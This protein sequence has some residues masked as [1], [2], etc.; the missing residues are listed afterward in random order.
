MKDINIENFNT[1]NEEIQDG[2][3]YQGIVLDEKYLSGDGASN[4]IVSI[5][6]KEA[7]EEIQNVISEVT[8]LAFVT[9]D[10]RGEPLTEMTHFTKFCQ[11]VRNDETR[12]INC[13]LS[14]ASGAIRAAVTKKTSNYFCPCGLLEVAIPIVVNGR[15]LGGFIGGQVRCY[16]APTSVEYITENRSHKKTEEDNEDWKEIKV[17]RYK[18]FEAISKLIELVIGQLTKQKIISLHHK[19]KNTRKISLLEERLSDLRCENKLLRD[20][21]DVLEKSSRWDRY[22]DLLKSFECSDF[23]ELYQDLPRLSAHILENI[24]D[25]RN[26][27]EEL[28]DISEEIFSKNECDRYDKKN[29]EKLIDKG[30]NG[31]YKNLEFLLFYIID[32]CFK[33]RAIR[34]HD[35]LDSVISYIE[36]NVKENISLSSVVNECSISQAY[37]S[38][39]FKNSFNTTVVNYIHLKKMMIAKEMLV[40][41]DVNISGL[42][43][44]LSY[45][46]SS[47]FCKVFKK[48]NNKTVEQYKQEM[49]NNI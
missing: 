39:I 26:A 32:T 23:L 44:Q 8:G 19:E 5:F 31:K 25:E 11:K 4:D 7:L 48:Y 27:A 41:E 18:E 47:Y 38:R 1:N 22:S 3:N 16:D 14:D 37:L 42:A 12:N 28:I 40:Y 34:T 36:E 46:E 43:F 9:V 21:I 10:Y 6:G 29:L 20:R 24:D 30:L 49:T 45:N 2:L 15:F 33:Y 35:I 13:K 17:Y